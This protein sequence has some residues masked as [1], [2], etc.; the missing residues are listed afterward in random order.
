MLYNAE[1]CSVKCRLL[2]ATS[3]VICPPF[4][5]CRETFNNKTKSVLFR[6]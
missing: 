3:I 4:P 6:I 1:A 5:V 2:L